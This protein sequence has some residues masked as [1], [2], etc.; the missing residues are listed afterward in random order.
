[1]LREEQI[2]DVQSCNMDALFLFYLW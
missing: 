1:M 2:D